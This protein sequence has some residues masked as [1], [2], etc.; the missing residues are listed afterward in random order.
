MASWLRAA[1]TPSLD[2]VNA[3]PFCCGVL[4]IHHWAA[5]AHALGRLSADTGQSVGLLIDRVQAG[6][7]E[8]PHPAAAA[9]QGTRSGAGAGLRACYHR[10]RAARRACGACGVPRGVHAD[11]GH[12]EGVF[13]CPST[14]FPLGLL[15][16]KPQ[17]PVQQWVNDVADFDSGSVVLVGAP[18]TLSATHRPSPRRRTLVFALTSKTACTEISHWNARRAAPSAATLRRGAGV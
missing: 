13:S 12:G 10:A 5:A 14:L 11:G 9:S 1:N 6:S 2:E 4:G 18:D 17:P 8:G 3:S 7:A 16:P 15:T